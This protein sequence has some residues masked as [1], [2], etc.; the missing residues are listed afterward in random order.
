MK[1]LTQ[2]RHYDV[3]ANKV[4][5]LEQGLKKAEK[6][7]AETRVRS[8]TGEDLYPRKGREVSPAF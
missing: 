1:P 4:K 2:E 5:H 8:G 3:S 6:R 7:I